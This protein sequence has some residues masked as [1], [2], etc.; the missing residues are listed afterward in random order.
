MY[1][2]ANNQRSGSK[3]LGLKTNPFIGQSHLILNFY[4]IN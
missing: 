1:L 3:F 2:K 4:S